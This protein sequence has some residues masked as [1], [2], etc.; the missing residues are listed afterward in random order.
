MLIVIVYFGGGVNV[1]VSG[2]RL[3]GVCLMRIVVDMVVFCCECFW[4][5]F[6]LE[7]VERFKVWGYIRFFR[8]EF[9]KL[10]CD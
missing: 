2:L 3:V 4:W 10:V 9:C 8:W 7:R 1:V 6:W 5:L